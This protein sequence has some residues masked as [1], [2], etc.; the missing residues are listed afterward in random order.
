VSAAAAP[1]ARILVAVD[2]S[3]ASDRAVRV[4]TALAAPAGATIRIVHVVDSPYAY[5]DAWYQELPADLAVLEKLWREAGQAVLDR[6]VALARDAGGQADGA[7]L[8]GG[9]RSLSQG[10][11]EEAEHW[12]ADLVVVGTRGRRVLEPLL[13]GSVAEGV[14]RAATTSVLLVRGS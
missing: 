12:G 8:E 10:V 5:P 1:F 2:G 7:L 3:V 9:G 13:L 4:A 14:A 11:V 6:A